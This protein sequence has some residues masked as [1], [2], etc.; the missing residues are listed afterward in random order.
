MDRPAGSHPRLG[1]G[2]ALGAALGAFDGRVHASVAAV[3]PGPEG[4]LRR[5]APGQAFFRRLLAFG[6]AWLRAS[7]RIRNF[8]PYCCVSLRRLAPRRTS[9]YACVAAASA[10]LPG[11]RPS[12][13]SRRVARRA[14][15]IRE[16]PRKACRAARQRGP[17]KKMPGP[18][19]TRRDAAPWAAR[20]V[21]AR[22]KRAASARAGKSSSPGARQGSAEEGRPSPSSGSVLR[23]A[24][25]RAF[26]RF[27]PEGRPQK[28]ER[29]LF[30]T[31]TPRH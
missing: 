22:R 6:A 29:E 14:E 8:E 27:A 17:T 30:W 19:A 3:R 7:G 18:A 1:L 13:G 31:A 9:Q 15:Q 11:V 4:L 5:A 20:F 23:D 12:G 26:L 2:C 25:E 21:P 24:P 10:S 28:R 16:G